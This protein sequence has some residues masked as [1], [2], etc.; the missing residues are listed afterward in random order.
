MFLQH[1]CT[2]LE[3]EKSVSDSIEISCKQT[4]CFVLLELNLGRFMRLSLHSA[5]PRFLFM[6][7]MQDSTT[8]GRG[9]FLSCSEIATMSTTVFVD[10]LASDRPLPA[11]DGL[12]LR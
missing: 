10:T 9:K 7:S 3:K 2:G 11:I 4:P 5:A 12:E 8:C 6:I 1:R